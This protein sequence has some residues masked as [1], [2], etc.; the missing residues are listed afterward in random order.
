MGRKKIPVLGRPKTNPDRPVSLS[1]RLTKK[2]KKFLDEAAADSG[3]SAVEYIRT[4][5]KVSHA[6]IMLRAGGFRD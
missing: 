4:A 6:A 2:E 3:L 1:V 5:I